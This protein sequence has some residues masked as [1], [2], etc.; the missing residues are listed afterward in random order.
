MGVYL[1]LISNSVFQMCHRSLPGVLLSSRTGILLERSF[2]LPS[3]SFVL[4]VIMR[5]G[6]A[7]RRAR[8]KT[9]VTCETQAA[10]ERMPIVRLFLCEAACKHRVALKQMK[11]LGRIRVL[12]GRL[13]FASPIELPSERVETSSPCTVLNIRLMRSLAGVWPPAKLQ[14]TARQAELTRPCLLFLR[15]G[16]C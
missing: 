1:S 16:Q 3:G 15:K 6:E 13:D 14:R 7:G 2:L 8:R 9:G 11:A 10:R 4:P 5:S 12:D